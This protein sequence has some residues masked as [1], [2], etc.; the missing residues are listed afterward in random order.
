MNGYRILTAKPS[1]EEFD[2]F[3]PFRGNE[4]SNKRLAD[5]SKGQ[6]AKDKYGRPIKDPSVSNK[7]LT[8]SQ[9]LALQQ[10]QSANPNQPNTANAG[11]LLLAQTLTKR[12]L[13]RML[14]K[15]KNTHRMTEG[16]VI[17]LI[18][19]CTVLQH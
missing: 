2:D 19:F 3:N 6:Y 5:A 4:F 1:F 18:L 11:A 10:A 15:E 16:I 12:R 14:W 13:K 17:R 7:K 9:L 8:Y